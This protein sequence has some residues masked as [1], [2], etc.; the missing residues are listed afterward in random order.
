MAR[1]LPSR[2]NL[3]AMFAVELLR[4]YDVIPRDDL[5]SAERIAENTK[6]MC[7]TAY[8][9]ADAMIFASKTFASKSRSKGI[10]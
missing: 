8:V 5:T 6:R 9:L 1:Q 2:N 4:E 10:Q 3:A 7:V